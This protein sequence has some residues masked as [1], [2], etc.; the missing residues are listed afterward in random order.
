MSGHSHFKTIK[1]EKE[2][3]D[4]QRG[5]IFSKLAR[6]ISVAVRQGT[7]PATNPKLR[8]ALE[9]A[10]SFNLPKENIERA[11]KRG[12]GEI[13][14]A[15]LEEVTYEGFG[16]AGIALII[17]G[18]TDNKNRT[19]SEIKRILQKHNAKLAAEGS[20]KWLFEQKGVI[21][22]KPANQVGLTKE[23]LEMAAIEAGAEDIRWYKTDG[24]VEEFLNVIT[25]PESL[26][27]VKKA[28]EGKGIKIE[29]ASLDWVAKEEISVS[30]KDKENCQK[31]FEDLD[32]NDAVQEIYSNLKI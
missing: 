17:E 26:H 15:R 31:L 23:N 12:A 21:T 19:L 16:P 24:Q 32:E 2:V 4:A 11:I 30:E 1:R 28:M 3:H 5:K 9:E 10:K 29:S 14:S 6:M 25:K 20:V 18:I 22:I 13:E 8:Q 27:E 7:D